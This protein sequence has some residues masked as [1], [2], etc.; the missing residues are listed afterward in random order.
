NSPPSGVANTAGVAIAMTYV[1]T[2]NVKIVSMSFG[3][4]LMTLTDRMSGASN[5]FSKIGKELKRFGN[6]VKDFF[7]SKVVALIDFVIRSVLGVVSG[8]DVLLLASAGNDGLPITDYPAKGSDFAV[9]ATEPDPAPS[10]SLAHYDNNT[11]SNYG[12]DVNIA[13]N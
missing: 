11:G 1:L 6:Q 5:F 10:V 2:H 9:G 7:I 3:F 13:A 8:F 12:S 4:N